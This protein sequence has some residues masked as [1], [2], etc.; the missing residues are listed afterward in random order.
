MVSHHVCSQTE[1]KAWLSGL[2]VFLSTPMRIPVWSYQGVT[3]DTKSQ[4]ISPKIGIK[5]RLKL[6]GCYLE[7]TFLTLQ[8]VINNH[9]L[10]APK[11]D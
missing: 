10:A 8:W 6:D 11:G 1:M 2:P 5:G 9:I 4:D 7:I 3:E